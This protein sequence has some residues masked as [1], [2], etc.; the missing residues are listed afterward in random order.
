MTK[1]FRFVSFQKD[2]IW[3]IW[4]LKGTN[5]NPVGNTREVMEAVAEQLESAGVVQHR[6]DLLAR[7]K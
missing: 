1:S 2:E 7:K 4:P 5:G 6:P 3:L